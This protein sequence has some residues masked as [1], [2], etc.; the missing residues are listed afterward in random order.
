MYEFILSQVRF[1]F[2]PGT[3]RYMYI[4]KMTTIDTACSALGQQAPCWITAA[5]PGTNRQAFFSLARVIWLFLSRYLLC[6][7]I[8]KWLLSCGLAND[9]LE[10]FFSRSL[11]TDFIS[12]KNKQ[13]NV[14]KLIVISQET[15][16]PLHVTKSYTAL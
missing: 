10:I 7:K 15:T 5:E 9:C 11:S 3:R 6:I 16:A 2:L 1:F 14:Y 8:H 12:F 4:P 13:R